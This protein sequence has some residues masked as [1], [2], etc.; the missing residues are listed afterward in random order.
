MAGVV[1]DPIADM[2]T[3]IRNGINARHMK[4]PMPLSKIKIRIA[5]CLKEEGFIEDYEVQRASNPPTLTVQLK[6][7]QNRECV[8]TGL[9]RVSRPGL[10]RYVST[11]EIPVI[12]NGLGISILSTS[13]GVM[14]D[15]EARRRHVGGELVCTVW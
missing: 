3:R 5:D 4:V 9:K 1:I 12:R 14:T 10:R 8:I 2:L 13:S 15:R 11:E 7:D 6:Y